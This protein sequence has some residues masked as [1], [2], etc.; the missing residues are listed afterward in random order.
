MLRAVGRRGAATSTKDVGTSMIHH[1][2][3]ANVGGKSFNL[4]G[5]SFN[6]Q[7]HM[8]LPAGDEREMRM[9]LGGARMAEG[10]SWSRPETCVLVVRAGTGA[11]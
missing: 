4:G 10:V 7:G 8:L 11:W 2:N 3:A 6:C 1:A 5:K 9:G